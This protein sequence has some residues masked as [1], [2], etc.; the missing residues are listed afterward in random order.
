MN[1]SEQ[2]AQEFLDLL[3][4]FIKEIHPHFHKPSIQLEDDFE[5]D[6]GLDSLSRVELLSRI[7]EHYHINLCE[8]ELY[9]I[10]NPKELLKTII[11]AK[12]TLSH[13][14]DHTIVSQNLDENSDLPHK[15][16]TLIDVLHWHLKQ[17]PQRI[18][19]QMYEDDNSGKAISYQALYEKALKI[20]FSLQDLGLRPSSAVAIMLPTCAEYFYSF[21]GILL[22]G[23]IP[24]PIYPPARASQLEE[25]VKRH[26]HILNNCETTI[27][28]TVPEAKV[29]AQLLKSNTQELQ[30]IITPE[31]LLDT[32]VT[33]YSL[34]HVHED[35][36][37]FIQYTSGSTGD[38][39]GVVLTHA[40]LLANIRA[41]GEAVEASSKDVFVSW[42]PL[43]H[44]MGLIGSWLGSI[45]HASVFVVM[46]PLS[47]LSKPQ[48]WLWAIHQYKGTLSASP[49]F[50]YEY[51]LHRLKN[52]DLK[53]LDLSSWRLAFNGAEAVS[54]VTMRNFCEHFKHYGFKE[55][56]M[57]PVYGLAESSVGLVFPPLHR[58]A[59]V[60]HIQRDLF[61]K[62]KIAKPT[63]D[64]IGLDFVSSGSALKGHEI[65]I[66]DELGHE[67]P[68]RHEG[69]LQFKGPS[70]TKGY[71]KNESKTN[72]LLDKGWLNTGDQAY[73]A[74]G[75]LFITG[76]VKD[77]II[78]A[79]RNIYPDQLEKAIGHIEG[80]RKGCVAIFGIKD[81]SS[82]TER[83]I[84]LAE[85][86]EMEERIREE[87]IHKITTLSGELL[88][89]IADKVVLA[90]TGAVLKTSSGKIRRSATKELYIR[91]KGKSETQSLLLQFSRLFLKSIIPNI[92]RLKRYLFSYLF[93]FY[94]WS[95]FTIFASLAW[96]SL[97]LLPKS[98]AKKTAKFYLLILSKI[99]FIPIKTYGLEHVPKD[100]NARVF[101]A[102]HSS[103]LDGLVLSLVLPSDISFV[104][105]AELKTHFYTRLPL[106]KLGV[107]FVQRFE[108]TQSVQDAKALLQEDKKNS[109]LVIFPEGT[110][111]CT[112]G[113]KDFHM[114]AFTLCVEKNLPLTAI[115]ISGTR[116]ILRDK[117]YFISQGEINVHISKP[118][119]VDEKAKKLSPW[120]QALSLSQASRAF[121]LKYS[122]EPDLQ[123]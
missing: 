47:F 34:P 7:Q 26:T 92:K 48:R 19:I 100:K 66:V 122:G 41:M 116:F 78:R 90:E 103:Y 35:D 54:P 73:M 91:N 53:G 120:D 74:E 101:V 56:S 55:T 1:H 115:S 104:A 118:I 37:A 97:I 6:L 65:R 32:E 114:G 119:H 9:E 12:E 109:S 70:S 13:H 94:H 82:G 63:Q 79:G 59:L 98:L 57:T 30:H 25:H 2:K 110:F 108:I 36:T 64:K 24:V 29:V 45:Y 17:H 84:I 71:Y 72:E 46:S 105:K 102:N 106:E 80:I 60:D 21:Y 58:G 33:N 28:I 112:A 76:R 96:I 111:S 86:K 23:G 88:G 38:P 93:S 22:A 61:M 43:Y 113:L 3:L 69:S 4:T 14:L 20:A 10:Q 121:I 18:H 40:N 83:L 5:H 51:T 8:E 89:A 95:V 52:S 11:G 75:E 44:D 31:Q 117:N 50:A 77:I 49:N 81:E 85:T 15:A 87:L 39:K 42:L 68:P 67:L 123:N 27:L 99:I 16:K 62:E 107:R